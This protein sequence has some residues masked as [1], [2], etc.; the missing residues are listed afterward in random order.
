MLVIGVQI[1]SDGSTLLPS[2]LP[3][4]WTASFMLDED[5]LSAT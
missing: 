1:I 4:G 5:S 3:S 2:C